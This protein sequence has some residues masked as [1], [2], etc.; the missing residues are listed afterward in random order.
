MASF[1]PDSKRHVDSTREI[2]EDWN[3]GCRDD[4]A[5]ARAGLAALERLGP[6]V[7]APADSCRAN[8]GATDSTAAP[9]SFALAAAPANSDDLIAGFGISE[10]GTAWGSTRA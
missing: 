4:A 2:V 7:S 9:R 8:F 5:T 1:A 3:V 6:S 10:H